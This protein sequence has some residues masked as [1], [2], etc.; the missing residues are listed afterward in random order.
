MRRL[1]N[2]GHNIDHQILDNEV[3]AEFKTTMEDTW[4]AHYQLIP[5]NVHCHNATK[6]AIQILKSHFLAIIAGLAPAFPRYLWDLLLP[7]TK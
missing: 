6:R 7:Q 2:H 4:K 1:T 3:S 5:P